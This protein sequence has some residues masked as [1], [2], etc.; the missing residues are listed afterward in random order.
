MTRN[1]WLTPDSL[2]AQSTARAICIPDG[3]EWLAA[4]RGALLLLADERNWQQ[5]G[6][7]TESQAAEVW[8]DVFA[9]FVDRTC[10]VLP[11]GSSVWW[12]GAQDT[13]PDNWLLCDGAWL[14]ENVWPDLFA[15]LGRTYGATAPFF[16]LPNMLDKFQLGA[17]SRAPGDTGGETNHTLT[18]DEIPAH[19]HYTPGTLNSGA[20][21]DYAKAG[22]ASQTRL[23]ET[24]D[25]GGGLSHNNMPPYL[26]ALPCIVAK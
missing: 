18:I 1:A 16:A 2:P 15:V 11:I 19:H 5:F 8:Q 26:V 20:N 9:A 7:V 23:F 22:D 24:T 17:G 4:F 3:N 21:S 13:I 14:H 25:T 6:S 12:Y 10:D